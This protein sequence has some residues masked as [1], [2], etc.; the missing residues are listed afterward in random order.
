[1]AQYGVGMRQDKTPA[2]LYN[3]YIVSNAA[4]ENL[5][6]DLP[7]VGTLV[8]DRPYRQVWRF[9]F[10]AKA[11][12][13]KFYPRAGNR[14]KRLL[15][16]NP[17]RVEFERL[18]ALQKA[19]IPAPRAVALL[20]GFAVNERAGDAVI[21]EAIEPGVTLDDYFQGFALRGQAVPNHR[22]L[23]HDI[24]QLV[25][26]LGQ[27]GL[28]H[29]DLHLGN[30]L[31]HEDKLYLLDGYA[32]RLG[33][34]RLNDVLQLAHS[35]LG[36]ATR[37]D[38]QRGWQ[39][40]AGGAAMPKHNRISQSW[41]R[42]LLRR[43]TGENA[44][45]GRLRDGPWRGVFFKREK[46]PRRW[47]AASG[48]EIS[49]TDW[50]KLWPVLLQQIES[51][52]LQILKASPSGDVLA[53]QIVLAGKT[54]EVIVKRPYKRYWYRYVNEMGRASRS[55]RAWR[56]AWKLILRDIPTA[57]P[58]LVMQKRRL[59]YITDSV[60]VFARVDGPTLAT[61][62]L[63]ALDPAQRQ[64]LFRR[65]GAILR[66]IETHGF[67]HFDAKASNWIVQH[68]DK[69]GPRPILIDVDG[70]RARRWVALGI[71]RLLRAMQEHP[72]YNVAD[73]L[74]LCQ[75]YAPYSRQCQIPNAKCQVEEKTSSGES[76]ANSAF[77]IRHLAFGIVSIPLD[78]PPQK[79]LIIKPS[80]IGDV[81]HA[82]PVLHLLRK[83]FG[84]ARISWMI[85][86]ACASLL[87]DHP[88]IDELVLFDREYLGTTWKSPAAALALWRFLRKLRA[89]KFDL[90]I[91]LQGLF[92]SGFCAWVTGA[93]R[94]VGFANA[95]EAATLFY[96]DT[97]E[98]SLEHDHAVERYLKLGAALGCDTSDVQFPLY[99][100]ETDRRY[101][102][103][104]LPPDRHFAVLL[105]GTNWPSKRWPVE[106]FA[107]LVEPLQK[108]HG[109]TCVVA[110]APADAEMA[111]KIP[112]AINL[113]GKTTLRQTVALLSRAK[114][115]IANDSGPMHIAAAL[116]VPLV[117]V[118]GPTNPVRT[119]P[120]GRMDS[121]LRLAM[122]CSPCYSRQCPLRH[123]NCLKLITPQ[124]VLQQAAA[125]M[126]T[127]PATSWP[128]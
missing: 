29:R 118:F 63:D 69:L 83:R 117:T 16:G 9:E 37:G 64:T 56:K 97:V 51:R 58:L 115:V 116:G 128:A 45:F 72:Q 3:P 26:Q 120:F 66:Q 96:T 28:G 94:R 60:I 123:H 36:L 127:T 47:A 34:L 100:D 87:Q 22:Q 23:S 44:Y 104:L 52:Q 31:L 17:A 13:L 114:L 105:P 32:V 112:G 49:P 11:Y 59:G 85:A 77:G 67:A 21:L 61:V 62:E 65:T 55:W 70:I 84:A 88:L 95:R 113:V 18:Q 15:A 25:H 38:L 103:T 76:A 46:Y 12:F 42:K 14:L 53:G 27:A 111:A 81:V 121:V 4:L 74:A 73:S 2:E 122:E 48:L 19:A 108:D 101:V 10:Q 82:L 110:G 33:G 7:K 6:R 20:V 57:W 24:R 35:V 75:G 92:R 93:P 106:Y 119:G 39:Q 68:D 5:L 86:P 1:M 71:R 126:A 50:Q 43:T 8:K 41:W 78:P 80:A 102:D 98:C 40:L 90:V 107:A 89:A 124:M 54:L 99:F 79:I 109:L 91:D 125:A 30:F